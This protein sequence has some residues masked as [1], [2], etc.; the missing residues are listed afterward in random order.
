MSNEEFEPKMSN[1]EFEPKTYKEEIDERNKKEISFTREICRLI[2]EPRYAKYM[3]TDKII[4]ERKKLADIL[5]KCF[6]FPNVIALL[7]AE[8][9]TMNTIIFNYNTPNPISYSFNPDARYECLIEN[10]T[11]KICFKCGFCYER[12]SNECECEIYNSNWRWIF[13][14]YCYSRKIGSYYRYVNGIEMWKIIETFEKDREYFLNL[15]NTDIGPRYLRNIIVQDKF[16]KLVGFIEQYIRYRNKV[17]F[18][19]KEIYHQCIDALAVHCWYNER[20]VGVFS[21]NL[22][23]F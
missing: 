19:M 13:S 21:N 12:F 6:K 7:I 20:C 14:D 9:A 23:N 15:P 2:L 22:I 1:E 18:H 5:I 16:N 17:D 8:F 10:E 3:V 11:N 4:D